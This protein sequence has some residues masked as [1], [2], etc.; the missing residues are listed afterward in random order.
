MASLTTPEYLRPTMNTLLAEFPSI[1]NHNIDENLKLLQGILSFGN[2]G[3]ITIPIKTDGTVTANTG[4]FRNLTAETINVEDTSNLKI[5]AHNVIYE[6]DKS[7]YDV[8]ST[9]DASVRELYNVLSLAHIY[10]DGA[11]NEPENEAPIL[12]AGRPMLT[13]AAAPTGLSAADANDYINALDANISYT[14]SFRFYN[15]TPTY[16]EATF[17]CL[18]DYRDIISKAEYRYYNVTGVKYV[19]V[20]NEYPACFRKAVRG[21][22]LDLIFH[23]T[24]NRDFIIKLAKGKSIKISASDSQ[25]ANLELICT[26]VGEDG[27][28][29]FNIVNYSGKIE[30]I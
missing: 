7:L 22:I 24:Q 1:V 8:I 23:D 29:T 12:S 18:A 28:C 20:T 11:V 27:E 14:Y 21:Q 15:S 4:R 17:R 9:I 25:I 26:G 3:Y 5:D 10:S 30:L 16:D 2:G 13:A 6:N 19:K